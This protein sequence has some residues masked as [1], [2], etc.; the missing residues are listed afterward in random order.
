M[1]EDPGLPG[2]TAPESVWASALR[3]SASVARRS[4]SSEADVLR[5]VTEELQRLNLRGGVSLITEDGRLEVRG[6]SI[7]SSLERTLERLSG[8]SIPGFRFDPNQ[9]DLYRQAI[10]SGHAVY[11]AR[12]SEVVRQMVP[13]SQQV[14]LPRII[15]LLGERPIIVAPLVL[16]DETI[17]AINVTAT[18]LRPVDAA[19]VA[20]LADHIAIALGHVRSRFVMA[21]SLRRERLRSEI[22][23]ALV[24]SL[25]LPKALDR[26]LALSIEAAD[27]DAAALAIYDPEGDCLRYTHIIGLPEEMRSSLQPRG[28]GLVWQVMERQE[29]LL[30]DDYEHIPEAMPEWVSVGL[31]AL[32]GIPLRL[33]DEA[34]G[35]LGVYRLKAG[36][37]FRPED[38]ELA[39]GI[40]RI[41]AIAIKNAGL[42]AEANRRAEESRTLIYTAHAI[43]GSLDLQTVLHTIAEEAKSL[44]KSD[45]SRIH[46]FDPEHNVLRAVVALHPDAEA[47]LQMGLAPRQGITGLVYSTSEPMIVNSPSDHPQ[48]IHVPGTPE[49]EPEIMALVPLT[50]RHKTIGVMT[51]LRF[52]E[53]VPYTPA[54][55]RLLEA[56]ATHAAIAIENADLFGQIAQHAHRL[57]VEVAA[58]TRDLALSEARYRALVETSLAGIL[59]TDP[60]GTLLYANQAFFDLTERAPSELL[61]FDLEHTAGVVAPEHRQELLARFRESLAGTRPGGEVVELQLLLPG[62]RRL[63]VLLASSVIADQDGAIQGLT[64]LIFDISKR[65]VLEAELRAER[66]RLHAILTNI[67]DAVIVTDPDG[68][69]EYVNPA[70]ERLNGYAAE[71]ALGRTPRILRSGKQGVET[72]RELWETLLSGRTWRG[73]LVNRRKDG[74]TYDAAVVITPVISAA[75]RLINIVGVQYDI[76]TLKELDRLKTQFVSDVSHELRTPLTNI[77][78]YL[79]LMGQTRDAQKSATYLETLLRESE[80]LAHLIDDLLDLSRLEAGA[81]PFS[82]RPVDL[83]RLLQALV[84]DRMALAAK[85]SLSLSIECDPGLP[86]AVGDER[87]LAQVF[88]NLLTNAMNYTPGGGKIRLHTKCR[89]GSDG[90]WVTAEVCDTGPGIP[91]EEQPLLF[92]RFFRGRAS[93]ASGASGTGLGLAICKEI[94]ELHGGRITVESESQPG[95][96]ARFTVWIPA[97]P[98]SP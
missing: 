69:I 56:F 53:E 72:Y 94:A 31:H 14:L 74:N 5:A 51:V 15:H 22:V 73:E 89:K 10:E 32:M 54:D 96:G 47:V 23:E 71:E 86:P 65:K 50:I 18:W 91:P 16:A 55:M 1:S 87:L 97:V 30:V 41:L 75:N 37:A 28:R 27:A 25:N 3:A 19:M 63:P 11:S 8:A 64:G 42:F 44:L 62:G 21:Q 61:G 7:S 84:N 85:R 57:E 98:A 40:G 77:R 83:N 34:I 78:L 68:V 81:T 70:W 45:G 13:P 60:Q 9:V 90:E 46:L 12:R 39:T 66:D 76:S 4:V 26:A 48:A 79:D 93:H 67:G 35:V 59:L 43:S 49:D 95:E 52:S 29:P 80:R 92:R 24:G 82:P 17:G 2:R 6:R 38:V 88:T 58:R 20:A 36:E 33:G